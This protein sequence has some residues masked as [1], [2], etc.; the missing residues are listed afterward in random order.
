[1]N[2][3]IVP[4]VPDPSGSGRVDMLTSPVAAA[5]A[6]VATRAW[7]KPKHDMYLIR[8]IVGKLYFTH[9]PEDKKNKKK[10]KGCIVGRRKKKTA[11]AADAMFCFSRLY[12]VL[13]GT[14]LS[15]GEETYLRVGSF[16][17]S[18]LLQA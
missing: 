16:L 18:L 7:V 1:M 10:K 3:C 11:P 9:P 4:T 2:G 6:A 5:R 8:G 12:M 14:F 17:R 13:V 15:R